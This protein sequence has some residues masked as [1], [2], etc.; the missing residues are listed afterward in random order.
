MKYDT[1]KAIVNAKV[2]ENTEQRITGGDMNNV[3]QSVIAS[4]GAHYQMGGLVSPNDQITVGDEPVVFLAT[5]PGTYTY[6]GG[7][8]VADGEVALL[9]WSGTAWSKQTPDISTRTEVSQL[10]Q[11]MVGMKIIY[12]SSTDNFL[13]IK[14]TIT[15][16][17][18]NEDHEIVINDVGGILSQF[19][20]VGDIAG[21]GNV[22]ISGYLTQ[23]KRIALF[24]SEAEYDDSKIVQWYNL[25]GTS[26]T[27]PVPSGA[28]YLIVQLKY[29][30]S[31][32]GFDNM[33]LSKS[34]TAATQ[35]YNPVALGF[36]G[37]EYLF[38]KTI[39]R[40]E[41]VVNTLT[42]ESTVTPLS[43]K[44]GKRLNENINK[45]F[46]GQLMEQ[47]GIKYP[48]NAIYTS[49]TDNVLDL[50]NV[51]YGIGLKHRATGNSIVYGDK[52]SITSHYIY[53]KGAS[54]VT[55]SGYTNSDLFVLFLKDS[56]IKHMTGLY[57]YTLT[58]TSRTVDVPSDAVFMLVG[59]QSGSDS[60]HDYSNMKVSLSNTAAT[61]A[62]TPVFLGYAEQPELMGEEILTLPRLQQK[63][64][65]MSQS[66][67]VLDTDVSNNGYNITDNPP[68]FVPSTSVVLSKPIYCKGQSKFTWKSNC[69][70][71]QAIRWIAF[72]SDDSMSE[73]SVVSVVNPGFSFNSDTQT[74]TIAIPSEASYMYLKLK[75]GDSAGDNWENDTVA[76][77]SSA[78]DDEYKAFV[79]KIGSK[80]FFPSDFYSGINSR[81][82]SLEED[83]SDYGKIKDAET[84]ATLKRFIPY[85]VGA[86]RTSLIADG[87]YERLNLLF[88]T[89]SHIDINQASVDNISDTID[90]AKK[91]PITFDA[92][93]HAGDIITPFG[94]TSKQGQKSKAA[95]FFNPCKE[96][97]V[98]VLFAVG[99]HDT[100]DW[101]NLVSNAF[102]D[103][104]WSEMW[105]DYAEA[106]YGIVR[107]TKSS[108]K[109]STW[110]YYDIEDKKVR[111]IVLDVL[112]A[113]K[114]IVNEN[115]K[116]VYYGGCAFYISNEQFNWV[117]NTALNFD[118]KDEK[119]WGVI[120]VSHL[121]VNIGNSWYGVN[122]KN[123]NDY[124]QISDWV[125]GASYV[126]GNLVKVDDVSYRCIEANSDTTFTASKWK[127]LNPEK[128]IDKFSLMLKAFN[129]QSTYSETYN[130]AGDSYFNLSVNADWT[131]YANIDKKPYII[132][133]LLGHEHAD[134]NIEK[135]GIQMIYTLNGSASAS[136]SDARV[137]KII[138]SSNQTA[139]DLISIDLMRKEIR[140]VRYGAGVNC[141]GEGGDRFLPNGLNY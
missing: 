27:I 113:D 40:Q 18:I 8:V 129:E 104:D 87:Q 131:R 56:V 31:G 48:M 22:T 1:L 79:T 67:N 73:D 44:Q 88:F 140:Y 11:K 118:D 91:C 111:V 141:Y 102:D 33:K 94:T 35:E 75:V 128:D 68:Y 3:L 65:Y 29:N 7:L 46:T 133:W 85:S 119:D 12:T 37:Q 110:H 103:D 95:L 15:T 23:N 127:E 17:R 90:F 42:S 139:F 69:N 21:S 108:G 122:C 39:L 84:A 9:V 101:S 24:L 98:P 45:L 106:T 57:N 136:S 36:I 50:N 53:V 34:A 93:I 74:K 134:M 82:K 115:N 32:E 16:Y 19:I 76:F 117:A 28:K 100:N 64:E 125:A 20:Y 26:R 61:S 63:Y 89:D 66:D 124:T 38:Y 99:N 132:C 41:D 123:P 92:I 59:L 135:N 72:C 107:Q 2:Y 6:F 121:A 83:R 47:N 97:S 114:T 120:V 71:V 80:V 14:N 86:P 25:T 105:Y 55:I 116:V 51:F 137:P 43:A 52:G 30:S 49:L 70:S 77:G 62:F 78:T 4:L 96:S 54:K 13:D 60:V 138:N 10:G 126:I 112:D 5:T 130:F 109:K 81:L 58:G